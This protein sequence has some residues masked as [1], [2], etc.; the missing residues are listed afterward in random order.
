MKAFLLSGA[1]YV[2]NRISHNETPKK[3]NLHV[4]PVEIAND[5]VIDLYGQKSPV[6]SANTSML[7]EMLVMSEQIEMLERENASLKQRLFESSMFAF[8]T[9]DLKPLPPIQLPS[10]GIEMRV[11]VTLGSAPKF[12][13]PRPLS[14]DE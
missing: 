6:L 10:K 12:P 11:H 7:D 8:E 14:D 9:Q 4:K 1:T 5:V 13:E 3:R 2:A